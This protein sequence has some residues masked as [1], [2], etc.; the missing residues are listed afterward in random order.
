[1]DYPRWRALME[2][3][4]LKLSVDEIAVGWHF[5]WD[6]DGLLVGPTMPEKFSCNC[7]DWENE[8]EKVEP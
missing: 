5:C 4:D 6:W 7:I 1:M 2:D 8:R 3:W